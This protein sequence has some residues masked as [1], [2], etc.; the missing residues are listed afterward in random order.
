[1]LDNK[2]LNPIWYYADVRRRRRTD[3][4]IN[5]QL[6]GWAYVIYYFNLIEDILQKK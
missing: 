1:M 3:E 2:P 6:S 4:L 5:K